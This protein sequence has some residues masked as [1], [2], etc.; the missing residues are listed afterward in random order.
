VVAERKGDENGDYE[1]KERIQRKVG[2]D[3]QKTALN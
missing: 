2:P 3:A 1:D